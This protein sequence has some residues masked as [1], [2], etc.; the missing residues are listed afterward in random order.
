MH[1]TSPD[2]TPQPD[3]A[4]RGDIYI[5]VVDRL[6]DRPRRR[7][8][9]AHLRPAV[10]RGFAAVAAVVAAA[11]IRA[12]AAAEGVGRSARGLALRAADLRAALAVF[13]R[14]S[15]ERASAG[16]R[17]WRARAGV[18]AAAFRAAA[19]GVAR[20]AVDAA[21]VH[22]GRLRPSIG[23]TETLAARAA[24]A[25]RSLRVA[26]GGLAENA[27]ASTARGLAAVRR[28]GAGLAAAARAAGARAKRFD[29]TAWLPPPR[30]LAAGAAVLV[31]TLLALTVAVARRRER[32]PDVVDV[33]WNPAVADE[34]KLPLIER[35]AADPS[36][37][38]TELL[39]S[40]VDHPSLL[41]SMASIRALRDRPCD[42]V[43][44]PLERQLS[45]SAW[46]RRAWAAKVVAENGCTAALPPVRARLASEP[47][48]RVQR[49]LVAALE[50]LGGRR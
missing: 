5:E 16:A 41:V 12:R 19:R 15:L 26:A 35:F 47:D 48:V 22:R 44:S 42:L 3:E 33:L 29:T 30:V 49:Q 28:G 45:D 24:H 1:L 13:G 27:T 46:Q 21:A 8:R 18:H 38:A 23:A 36:R 10:A 14:R 25:R 32:P 50:A 17:R 37:K 9:A 2:R 20:R 11:M 31:A 43:A 4:E 6:A 40:T 7:R 34:V 39:V